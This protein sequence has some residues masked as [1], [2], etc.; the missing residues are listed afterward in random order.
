MT[1]QKLLNVCT[2]RYV[3]CACLGFRTGKRPRSV[4]KSQCV[5]DGYNIV[6]KTII[7][8]I[9]EELTII[10]DVSANV[11][12]EITVED[13]HKLSKIAIGRHKFLQICTA[14]IRSN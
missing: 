2:H 1:E 11:Y 3:A 4:C 10:N 12:D 9:G 7:K 6:P 5:F 14:L 13:Y 8:E